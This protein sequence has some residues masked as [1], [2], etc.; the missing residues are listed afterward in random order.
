MAESLRLCKRQ[1][2]GESSVKFFKDF[3]SDENNAELIFMLRSVLYQVGIGFGHSSVFFLRVKATN[4]NSCV[5]FSKASVDVD[6]HRHNSFPLVAPLVL[7]FAQGYAVL[8]D[9]LDEDKPAVPEDTAERHALEDL[10][11]FLANRNGMSP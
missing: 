3:L 5:N 11:Q 2:T 7:F 1:N 4:A 8:A 6:V 9:F 10:L